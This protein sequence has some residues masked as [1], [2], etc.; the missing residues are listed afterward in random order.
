MTLSKYL[1]YEGVGYGDLEPHPVPDLQS[2]VVGRHGP[3]DG[4]HGSVDRQLH[5]LVGACSKG[6]ALEGWRGIRWGEYLTHYLCRNAR[7]NL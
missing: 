6:G 1:T 4:V 3:H 2:A 7:Y 5:L